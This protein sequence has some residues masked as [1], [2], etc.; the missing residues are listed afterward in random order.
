MQKILNECMK[1]TKRTKFQASKIKLE[2]F[3]WRDEHDKSF[4]KSKNLLLNAVEV[5]HVDDDKHLCL[6]CDALGK[7]YGAALTQI[8][9]TDIDKPVMDQQHEPLEFLSGTFKEANSRWSINCKEAYAVIWACR[10]LRGYLLRP[11]IFTI[12]CDHS[13]LK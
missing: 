8:P 1:G 4:K 3:N 7:H 2:K 13:N 10:K 12:Y 11:K 9:V 6:F 5:A